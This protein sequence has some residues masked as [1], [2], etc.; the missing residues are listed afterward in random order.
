MSNY[1]HKKHKWNFGLRNNLDSTQI[2]PTRGEK[3]TTYHL[4]L[5]CTFS[6]VFILIFSCFK[7]V[8]Q[9]MSEYNEIKKVFINKMYSTFF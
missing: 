9:Q 8:A 6:H 2:K 7:N 1:P 3:N 5:K 4:S